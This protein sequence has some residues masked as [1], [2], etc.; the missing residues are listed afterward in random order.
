VIASKPS[1]GRVG[2]SFVHQQDR[3]VILDGINA[4]ALAALEALP[5][6]LQGQRFLAN[7]ANKH[8]QQ[9]W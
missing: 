6:V 4:V 9:V 1:S 3:N 2:D 5:F 7:W 8:F